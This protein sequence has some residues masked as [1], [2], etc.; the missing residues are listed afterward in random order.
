MTTKI[1][2]GLFLG[3]AEASQDLEFLELN[4]ITHVINCAGKQLPNL[5]ESAGL[6]YLTF[7]WEDA[8]SCVVFD[9]AC[10]VVQQICAF[11]DDALRVGH[12]VLVH[13]LEGNSRCATAVMAYFMLR[14]AWGVEK[15]FEFLAS[16]RPDVAPNA[17]FMQQLFVLDKQLQALRARFGGPDWAQNCAAVRGR[18]SDWDPAAVR[19]LPTADTDK[20][21]END[22]LVLVNSFLNSMPEPEV[23][24]RVELEA[25]TGRPRVLRWADEVPRSKLLST[26]T[27][28]F[29]YPDPYDRPVGLGGSFLLPGWNHPTG[30][31]VHSGDVDSR[32]NVA[33]EISETLPLVEEEGEASG[34]PLGFRPGLAGRSCLRKP[35]YTSEGGLGPPL[36]PLTAPIEEPKP[37]QTKGKGDA[38]RQAEPQDASFLPYGDL[39]SLASQSLVSVEGIMAGNGLS[40][41]RGLRQGSSAA[42]DEKD[43]KQHEH[44]EMTQQKPGGDQRASPEPKPVWREKAVNGHA[45]HGIE[46]GGER[47]GQAAEAPEGRDVPNG[48]EAVANGGEANA[49]RRESS[50][51]R[52]DVANSRD[53]PQQRLDGA[54]QRMG[55]RDKAAGAWLE[56]RSSGQQISVTVVRATQDGA[57]GVAEQLAKSGRGS[58]AAA[59]RLVKQSWV[60]NAPEYRYDSE[61]DFSESTI[62]NALQV[63]GSRAA[64]EDAGW[65]EPFPRD[66]PA[67]GLKPAD[68]RPRGADKAAVSLPYRRPAEQSTY[69]NVSASPEYAFAPAEHQETYFVHSG[70]WPAHTTQP[71]IIQAA[72]VQEGRYVRGKP[73]SSHS[74]AAGQAQP[75]RRGRSAKDA[76]SGG[77]ASRPSSG[78][79]S[80][81]RNSFREKYNAKGAP[82]RATPWEAHVG[83]PRSAQATTES[84]RLYQGL[85]AV[86]GND[87]GMHPMPKPTHASGRFASRQRRGRRVSDPSAPVFDTEDFGIFGSLMGDHEKDGQQIGVSMGPA[88]LPSG[89]HSGRPE[90]S[91][92]QDE[93]FVQRPVSASAR[94]NAGHGKLH[95]SLRTRAPSPS[96]AV[97]C[98]IRGERYGAQRPNSA[99]SRRTRSASPH[100]RR[101]MPAERP[102]THRPKSSKGRKNPPPSHARRRE[103]PVPMR[104]RWR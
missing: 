57:G 8:E 1:K 23:L 33:K 95:S 104:P 73:F 59:P 22:E 53:T 43:V 48:R 49:N 21:P 28:G 68:C 19:D 92:T 94:L 27:R 4:K 51:N 11:V 99:G 58:G 103:S 52:R 38:E 47:N 78:R 10:V 26:E 32:G 76:A 97:E 61:H 24:P 72:R 17:G 83:R 84:R 82:V 75:S 100:V 93:A 70:E 41:T 98:G 35:K 86:L 60:D 89:Y 102:S 96:P 40:A 66:K 56:K 3:D 81:Q 79:R 39:E 14:Y 67:S 31:S 46:K 7:P 101:D 62:S 13:C 74:K 12:S 16:R 36:N 90:T 87:F 9:D 6:R 80:R 71:K 91:G 42:D 77:K 18:L 5:F 29:A 50:A 85:D 88:Q 69:R 34:P 44:M 20:H 54:V 63:Q 64:C 37:P 30:R 65:A 15:T 25:P 2:D 45:R 55:P